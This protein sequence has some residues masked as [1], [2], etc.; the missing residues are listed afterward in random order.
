MEDSFVTQLTRLLDHELTAIRLA[1]EGNFNELMEAWL[2]YAY[3]VSLLWTLSSLV[4]LF[5][6]RTGRKPASGQEQLTYTIMIPFHGE[7][8][9]AMK[10][11]RS[12]DGIT[13][14][15]V[16]IILID[17]GSPEAMPDN[18]EL[19]ANARLLRLEKRRGKAG[20][21]NAAFESV[22]SDLVVCLDADTEI[23][24]SDWNGLLREFESAEVGAVTGKIWPVSN[25]SLIGCFQ[26]LDYLAVISLIKA[27]ESTWG[28]LMTVSGAI[29]AYRTSALQSVGGFDEHKA[30]EDIDISW[31]LQLGGWRLTYCKSWTGAVEMAP[32]FTALWRQRRRWSSGLGQ[33]L[34][35]YALTALFSGSRNFPILLVTMANILWVLTMLALA[36]MAL[37][38]PSLLGPV[39]EHP[40][41]HVEVPSMLLAGLL[42]FA[43]QFVAATRI[44]GRPL[45][46]HLHLVPLLPLYPVY[47]WMVLLSSFLV[48]FPTGILRRKLGV[49]Q[50]TIRAQQ[51]IA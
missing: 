24:T 38:N 16:E 14:R 11:A 33:A 18:V 25:G 7:P 30:A 5:L 19:P 4:Y 28:G 1:F 20:A 51:I 40:L 3:A 47:F 46:R 23:K 43:L 6:R 2:V 39:L 31:R 9:G 13:P 22:T 44:D 34:R 49:W 17:D 41:L 10:T 27:A 8:L 35:D 15:P 21:L 50:P 37:V 42:L 36:V 32:N 48:G 29:V 12:L 45:N 26:E